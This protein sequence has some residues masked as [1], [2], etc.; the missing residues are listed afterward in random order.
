MSVTHGTA[1]KMLEKLLTFRD[2]DVNA[3]K[4]SHHPYLQ[5][6]QSLQKC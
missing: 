4:Y 6:R 3:D 5:G 1:T 2:N